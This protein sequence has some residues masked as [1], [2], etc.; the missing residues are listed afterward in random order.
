MRDPCAMT[1]LWGKR[2]GSPVEQRTSSLLANPRLYQSPA[3]EYDAPCES[4]PRFHS[5]S[6]RL[7]PRARPCPAQHEAAAT[8]LSSPARSK[9]AEGFGIREGQGEGHAARH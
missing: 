5:L 4:N 2:R 3:I 9:G 6:H 1:V 8:T 7:E